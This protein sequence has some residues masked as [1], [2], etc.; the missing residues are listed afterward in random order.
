MLS[1]VDKV[2]SQPQVFGDRFLSLAPK[3][4]VNNQEDPLFETRPRV[5]MALFDCKVG[6]PGLG[7]GRLACAR[8]IAEHF[9]GLRDDTSNPASP[10]DMVLLLGNMSNVDVY[11]QALR[12]A[13]FECLVAGGS[14]FSDSLE[15]Q[16]VA[17]MVRLFFELYR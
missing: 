11:A 5:S 1:F 2:F 4:A 7:A 12:D 10:S 16:L 15:V 13:G 17:S 14:T 6:G 3:G 9:A 8:R